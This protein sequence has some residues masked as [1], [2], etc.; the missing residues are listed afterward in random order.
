MAAAVIVQVLGFVPSCV[1]PMVKVLHDVL[2]VAH[3][4][5]A[6]VGAYAGD[7]MPRGGTTICGVP[8]RLDAGST[9]RRYASRQISSR[10]RLD[11][12]KGP[13]SRSTGDLQAL[14][15]SRRRYQ[16]EPD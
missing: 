5:T 10:L 9:G 11:P 14:S 7:Q 3:G 6:T 4:F 2:G 15:A 1:A 16:A 13:W 12:R 8:G